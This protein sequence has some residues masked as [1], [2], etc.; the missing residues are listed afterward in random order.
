MVALLALA[1]CDSGRGEGSATQAGEPPSTLLEEAEEEGAVLVVVELDVPYRP[2]AEL[3]RDAIAAQRAAI[4][5]AQ[6]AVLAELGEHGEVAGRPE[7]LPQL[8]LRVDEEG[9]RV[10]AR[11]PYVRELEANEPEPPSGS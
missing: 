7:R 10:L 3:G 6:E 4:V 1:A 8:A 5:E 2:E 9:L 11:S